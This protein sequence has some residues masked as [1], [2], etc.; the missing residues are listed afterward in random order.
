MLRPNEGLLHIFPYGNAST[1]DQFL[2]KTYLAATASTYWL[3]VTYADG[4]QVDM[5]PLSVGIVPVP[6]LHSLLHLTQSPIALYN[7][8]SLA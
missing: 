7:L 5:G 1:D 8:D 4:T 6:S 3:Q 2:L